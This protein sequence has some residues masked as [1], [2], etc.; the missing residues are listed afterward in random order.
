MNRPTRFRFALAP[1]AT[2]GSA[3]ALALTLAAAPAV[4]AQGLPTVPAGAFVEITSPANGSTVSGPVTLTFVAKRIATRPA[5]Q[6]TAGEGHHHLIIDTVPPAMGE[7][8]P[9]DDQ[10]VHFGKAQTQATLNLSPGV[11]TI[12]AQFADGL[13]R[14]YGP[15]LSDTIVI[16]VR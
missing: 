9:A 1:L 7:T 12:T 13:H 6:P 4:Q 3:L 2:L 14:S 16:R 10:H 5:G 15:I 8:I 11:H